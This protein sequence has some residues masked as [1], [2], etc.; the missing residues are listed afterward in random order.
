ML[1]KKSKNK[2]KKAIKTTRKLK[3]V[4]S[5]TTEKLKSVR[6]DEVVETNT[7]DSIYQKWSHGNRSCQQK[8]RDFIFNAPQTH[9]SNPLTKK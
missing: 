7:E 8:I 1:A 9:I 4:L 3:F 5:N 2:Q 6:A